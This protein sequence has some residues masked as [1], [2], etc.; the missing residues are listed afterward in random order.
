MLLA[1][2]AIRDGLKSKVESV[3]ANEN[4]SEEV[5]AACK[6][7]LDTYAVGALNGTATD[8]LVAALDGIDCPTCKE[9]VANKDFLAKKSQWIFGGDGWAYDI[10]FGGVDHVLASGKDINIMVYD[11]EVYSNTGGQAS[12]STKTGAVAQL[13]QAVKR[14]RRKT[15]LVLQ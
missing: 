2:N 6:E 13:L 10:G 1:Q 15:L 9:I 3:M 7:W 12:K 5:K 11:T 14:P 4:A 8:K